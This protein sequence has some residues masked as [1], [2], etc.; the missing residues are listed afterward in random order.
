MVPV[1]KSSTEF[2]EPSRL[3]F[4]LHRGNQIAQSLGGC[5]EPEELAQRV[6]DGL[7]EKFDCALARI[8]LVE[9]DR[10]CLRLVSSSGM[11][12]RLDG[13]FAKVPMGAFKVG[14]IAQNGIP[15]LS[16]HLA[17]ETWVRDREW[18]IAHSILGFAGYPLIA[19]RDTVGVLAIFSR[20]AMAPEFLEVLQSL[21][22]TVTVAI[23]NALEYQQIR[24]FW[25]SPVKASTPG[26]PPLS[27]QL[28]NRLT[29]TRLVLVGTERPLTTPLTCIF[30]RATEVLAQTQCI[31]CRL[32]YS[33]QTISLEA[34]V[35]T[36]ST[37]SKAAQDNDEIV[38]AFGDILF[39]ASCL[40]GTLQIHTG[41][42]QKVLQV[43]LTIP[44]PGCSLGPQIRISCQLP[45]LQMAFT[46]LSYLAG[47]TVCTTLD[48]TVP[49]LTDDPS[50]THSSERVLWI[51]TS[52]QS[53]PKAV[54]AKLDLS[55]SPGQL[56][57]A[58]EAVL[59]GK[60]WE[61]GTAAVESQSLSEREQE[62]MS[63][64][65]VGLRDRDIAHQ[66]YISERTVK[67]H[68]NN[69]LTKL[70]ARTR[71]QAL[72]QATLKGWIRADHEKP[73]Q[74]NQKSV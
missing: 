27:E 38:S 55:T 57:E 46:H 69:I 21:C 1:S 67:F 3:L 23:E 24:Q 49:L 53:V 43:L 71:F 7:V 64:L 58:V 31:Y 25:Q 47:L 17:D 10:T 9:P 5:L 70:K 19:A 50:Q 30:L 37:A 29:S 26:C 6:T 72:Y 28:S 8:W 68:I 65:A 66:L 56:R 60:N 42:N 62:I 15:F 52:S 39:A 16:N 34:M 13:S 61:I 74:L 41:I 32:T 14:K 33:T 12:T 20:Q 73:A 59:I 35:S 18:A 11:Y 48:P 54:K 63:L 22:T 2:L 36:G 4:D 40:G 51:A 44:Y 45:V